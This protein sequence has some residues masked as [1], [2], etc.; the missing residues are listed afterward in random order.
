[1]HAPRICVG[2]RLNHDETAQ[3]NPR[4]DE[5]RKHIGKGVIQIL[6]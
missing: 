2:H 1:M 6:K 3:K 4:M 5:I